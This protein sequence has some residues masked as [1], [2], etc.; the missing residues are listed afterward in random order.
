[1]R[2]SEVNIHQG[3]KQ[4]TLKERLHWRISDRN[5]L[6]LSITLLIANYLPLDLNRLFCSS[7]QTHCTAKTQ[8]NLRCFIS[9]SSSQLNIPPL[10]TVIPP[11]ITPSPGFSQPKNFALRRSRGTQMSG[12]SVFCVPGCFSL[13]A[14]DPQTQPSPARPE[15]CRQDSEP[16][17]QS[18]RFRAGINICLITLMTVT[19]AQIRA[20]KLPC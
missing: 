9:F 13:T 10:L 14:A 8:D 1:M 5:A 16:D 11:F 20:K 7:T 6:F 4:A 15:A 12:N 2:W 17:K 19:F 3:D 18:H